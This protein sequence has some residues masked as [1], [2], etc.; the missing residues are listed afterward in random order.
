MG[1]NASRTVATTSGPTAKRA[2]I[3]SLFL[4][5]TQLAATRAVIADFDGR[6]LAQVRHVASGLAGA[7]GLP[8]RSVPPEAP[9]GASRPLPPPNEGS[10]LAAAH[11]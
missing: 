6:C 2:Q 1:S 8:G 7:E 9:V 5:A 3:A 11:I 4:F 10:T